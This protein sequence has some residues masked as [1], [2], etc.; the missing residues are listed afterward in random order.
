MLSPSLITRKSVSFSLI[1][2][3]SLLRAME[4][5]LMKLAS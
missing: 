2:D 5:V 4:S 3:P 1:L